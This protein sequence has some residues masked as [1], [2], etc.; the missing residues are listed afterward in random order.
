MG[1]ANV[2]IALL[3]I[4]IIALYAFFRRRLTYWER[5]NFPYMKPTFPFGNVK[6]MLS[7]IHMVDIVDRAYK[8]MKGK[9][10]FGGIYLSITP[11]IIPLD[12][13]FIKTILV[14]DYNY[15]NSHGVYYN[16]RDDPVTAHLIALN[17]PQWKAMR[18]KL[19]PTFT[20]GKMKFMYPTFVEVANRLHKHLDG[21]CDSETACDIECKDLISS[22]TADIIGSCAFGIECNSFIDSKSEFKKMGQRAV[23]EFK[24][25]M[26]II[27]I[28]GVFKK[29]ARFF[30]MKMYADD[31]GDFFCNTVRRNIEYREENNVQRNDFLDILIKM[32]N[33][34]DAAQ[35]LTLNE[36]AAQSFLFFVAGFETSATTVT[37]ALH[38]L[39][40]HLNIQD[41][42]REEISNVLKEHSGDLSYEAISQMNYIDMI[43]FGMAVVL[44]ISSI[45]F[46]IQY[47]FYSRNIEKVSAG[48]CR[49][50]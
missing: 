11:G 10:I 4:V 37:M 35:R 46:C 3:V 23:E 9:G 17:G 38:E 25:P 34:K 41:K 15:F 18:E 43:I 32:K 26:L 50:T 6:G 40:Q 22:Y 44:K 42:A 2:T 20:P 31:I 14:R 39:A 8:Q 48:W 28:M 12:L 1:C 21:I 16:E 5:T 13:D 7:E 47:L 33:S 49:I 27:F 24:Y 36:I 30:R 19:T 29:T 45:Y